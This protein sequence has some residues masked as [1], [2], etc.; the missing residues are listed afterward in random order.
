LIKQVRQGSNIADVVGGQ[1]AGRPGLKPGAK[2]WSRSPELGPQR[3][4]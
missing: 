2:E 3:P 4:R 1:F